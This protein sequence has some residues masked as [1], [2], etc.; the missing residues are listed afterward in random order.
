MKTWTALLVLLLLGDLARAATGTS[1]RPLLGWWPARCGVV[2][3][4][5][6]AVMVVG[7]SFE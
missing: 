3:V 4:I 5:G 2:A 7:T 1:R 6:V